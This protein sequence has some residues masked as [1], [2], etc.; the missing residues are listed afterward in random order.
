MKNHLYI[1]GID[2]S[3]WSERA[4]ERAV[5]L[6]ESTGA[7]VKLLYVMN[8]LSGVQP[9]GIG[10]IAVPV[11]DKDQEEKNVIDHVLTPLVAKLASSDVDVDSEFIWGDPAEIIQKQ[12]KDGHAN[13]LFVGRRGRS[14]FADI[15]LGSVANKLAHSIGVPIVLVP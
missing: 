3:D 4:A 1:V 12:V 2:G 9:V 10:A 8:D 15:L 5:N 11:I 13:M 14:R 6:A 7:K